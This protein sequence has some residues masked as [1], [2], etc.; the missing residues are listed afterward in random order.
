MDCIFYNPETFSLTLTILQ[1]HEHVYPVLL[2]LAMDVLLAQATSV[3]CEGVF[4]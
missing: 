2:C 3:P 4:C 1:K